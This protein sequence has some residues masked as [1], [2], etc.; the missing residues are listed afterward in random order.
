MNVW[1]SVS[2]FFEEEEVRDG[3]VLE[4]GDAVN[5][6]VGTGAGVG[7]I[8]GDRGVEDGSHDFAELGD[9][10]A[11]L[12]LEELDLGWHLLAIDLDGLIGFRNPLEELRLLD[13][14]IDLRDRLLG[15]G[16][17][18]RDHGDDLVEL[19]HHDPPR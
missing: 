10:L 17:L 12:E 5:F 6:H 8:L 16:F 1:M 4:D 11:H 9:R 15:V 18:A 19:R 13:L 2:F 3:D 7:D 14:V